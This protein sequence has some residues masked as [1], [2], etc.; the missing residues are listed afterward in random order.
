M[1]FPNDGLLPIEVSARHVHLSQADQDAL[2]GP[3]YQMKI[4]KELSQTGQWAA[5]ETV[6]VKGPKGEW[7]CRVL[8]PCRPKTQ[9][10]FA[11]SDGFKAGIDVPMRE[12]GHLDGTPGCTIVGPAGTIEIKEGVIDPQ[13]HL[14]IRDTEAAEWG[15]EKGDII[16]F[17]VPGSQAA[18]FHNAVVRV[19]PT[20]RC[21]I[22]LDTDEGNA[23]S[24]PMQ[25]G[26]AKLVKI[27]RAGKIIFEE[28]V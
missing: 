6:V 17:Y 26:K 25:G 8:G 19:H 28:K 14:H 21:N 22:H 9:V 27:E 20:F 3:G 23:C 7:K 16:S 1:Q 5:E 10:E 18:T 13:R 24:L 11:F 4:K 12:S 2:F 15:L